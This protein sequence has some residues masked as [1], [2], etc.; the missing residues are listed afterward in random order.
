MNGGYLLNLRGC[1]VTWRGSLGRQAERQIGSL[2]RGT[3]GDGR[4]S[5]ELPYSPWTFYHECILEYALCGMQQEH[6]HLRRDNNS[7]GTNMVSRPD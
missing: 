5:V 1:D 3:A 7:V 2:R 6:Q 4:H